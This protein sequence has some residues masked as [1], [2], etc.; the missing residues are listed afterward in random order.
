[1][2]RVV[3][4]VGARED[5]GGKRAAVVIEREKTCPTLI[6]VFINSTHNRPEAYNSL[7]ETPLPN[8]LHIYTWMDATLREIA[9]LIRDVSEDARKHSRLAISIVVPDHR[10]RYTL[11]KAGA[12]GGRKL[13]AD[14]DKTLASF[15]FQNGDFLDVAMIK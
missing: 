13:S 14:E 15:G 5:T 12:V 4:R 9:G 11:R 2:V 1:M 10:G 3:D 7:H 6:R 8:E